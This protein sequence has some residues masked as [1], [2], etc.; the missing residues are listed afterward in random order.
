MNPQNLTQVRLSNDDEDTICRAIVEKLK[1]QKGAR[2]DEV[3]KTA[4]DEGRVGLATKVFC[5][6]QQLITV[7]GL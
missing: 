1:A 7:A 3:A 4:F 2:F 6:L 5:S